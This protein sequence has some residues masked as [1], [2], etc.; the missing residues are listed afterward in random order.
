MDNTNNVKKFKD[1][2]KIVVVEDDKFLGNLVSKKL[3]EDG[4]IVK[5]VDNG[6]AASGVVENEMPDLV[7]MDVQMPEISGIEATVEIRKYEQ[8]KETRIPIVA[9]TAGAIK[10]ERERCMEA[11]MDDFLTK[12]VDRDALFKM[13]E[14]HLVV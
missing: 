13:L 14:K 3:V 11:G 1:G 2:T 5:Y 8:D 9:L 10:G 7:F 4:C 6:E 12:P